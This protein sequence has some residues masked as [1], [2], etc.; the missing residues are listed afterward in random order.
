MSGFKIH[1]LET[2]PEGS[3]EILTGIKK[4]FGAIP[5]LA[6]ILAES[7]AVLKAYMALEEFF[8]KTSLTPTERLVVLLTIS[9]GNKC[10]Y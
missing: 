7:P 5:N 3:V 10:E 8:E 6:G 4:R 1:K 2:A 9:F